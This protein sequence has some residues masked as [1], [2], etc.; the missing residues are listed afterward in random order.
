[1]GE[2][3]NPTPLDRQSSTLITTL[4]STL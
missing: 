1:M 2:Y 3:L 4:P